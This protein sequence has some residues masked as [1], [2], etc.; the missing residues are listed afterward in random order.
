MWRLTSRVL[1]TLLAFQNVEAEQN[2][3]FGVTLS[4]TMPDAQF[5]DEKLVG[6]IMYD[7]G[8]ALSKQLAMPVYY[9]A[10][11]RK[12]IGVEVRAGK[13]D[14]LCENNPKWSEA[15][16]Q[17]VWSEPLFE[18]SIVIFGHNSTPKLNNVANIP[19]GST[20]STVLGYHYPAL[21]PFFNN[22]KLTREDA[23]TEQNVILKLNAGR[24]DYGVSE[25]LVLSW[26]KKTNPNHHVSPWQLAISSIG[27]HCAIP[28][29]GK[30]PSA[31]IIDALEELK[32]KGSIENILN[33]YR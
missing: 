26:Y 11:P 2:L 5:Q 7:L 33:K 28:L 8:Q 27:S 13:A 6:G 15:P 14:I 22:G 20:I 23:I 12:R 24:T 9:V 18:W 30:I 32:R 19:A 3:R 21:D 17:Y 10:L 4:A 29:K 31:I 16:E 25:S 1:I